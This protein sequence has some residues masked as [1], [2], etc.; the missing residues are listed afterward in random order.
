MLAG[1]VAT[2]DMVDESQIRLEPE[3]DVEGLDSSS[4]SLD[5][6]SIDDLL[7]RPENRSIYETIRRI[8][9][10]SCVMNPD[11]QREFIWPEDKQ[12]KLIES[13]I[14]RIPLPVFYFAEDDRGRI[15]VVDGLQRLT[16]INRFLKDKLR[17]KLP[18]RPQLDKQRFSDLTPK[19]KNRIE[20]F[21]LIFYIIDS[22]VPERVRLDVFERVNWGIPLTRQ[23]MRNCLY[24]GEATRFLRREAKTEL[25]LDATGNSLSRETMRDREFVNRFC[26][27]QLLGPTQYRGDM[28]EFLA[29]SLYKMN[30]LGSAALSQLSMEFRR[31]LRSNLILFGE[32]AFRRHR[33][34]QENRNP[35]NASFWDVMTTGLSM[36][37]EEHT[38]GYAADV[39][40]AVYDLL[41][42]GDFISAIT[43][44]PNSARTVKTRFSLA[45]S[46]LQG[47]LGDASRGF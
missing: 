34:G 19:I 10:G 32:H 44:G 16:S 39:R 1:I 7:I 18:D 38:M 30:N 29:K 14:M 5:E 36:Y 22:D 31:G 23:Q 43:D 46:A 45:R 13:I 24:M 35:L 6:Y 15:V 3:S 9:H 17:L 26:A 40:Q 28:D 42:N 47:T 33:A 12:S 27:F 2:R 11:I 37:T 20:D 4:E 21:N 25:F 8:D 41:G